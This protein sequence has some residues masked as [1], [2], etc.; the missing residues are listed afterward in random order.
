MTRATVEVALGTHF[1]HLLQTVSCTS[2]MPGV[3]G[4]ANDV[5]GNHL[6][7]K[8]KLSSLT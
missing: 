7:P 6:T 3:T 8:F 5:Q 4:R 2:P 1:Y